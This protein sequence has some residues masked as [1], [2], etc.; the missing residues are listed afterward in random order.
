MHC[1][2]FLTFSTASL[3]QATPA[4]IMRW[5]D[6]MSSCLRPLSFQTLICV[7]LSNQKNKLSCKNFSH[8]MIELF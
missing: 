4:A 5:S 6:K 7:I 3:P 8:N 1:N 2:G